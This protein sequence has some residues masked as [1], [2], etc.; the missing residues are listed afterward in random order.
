M[1][2]THSR[3]HALA[4]PV[5][6]DRDAAAHAVAWVLHQQSSLGGQV[7]LYVPQRDSAGNEPLLARLARSPGVVTATWRNYASSADWSGGPVLAA[8]PDADHL[9]RVDGDPRSRALC[10]L[11]WTVPDVDAWARARSPLQLGAAALEFPDAVSLDPV[12]RVALRRL[13]QMVNHANNLAG[14]LD[15]RDAIAVLTVLHRAGYRLPKDEVCAFALAQGW[16][17]RGARRLRDWAGEI[18]A[19]VRKRVNGPWPLREDV[20]EVWRGESRS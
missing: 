18:D 20:I 8:W 2:E 13:G 9:G 7:L 16:P 12:V 6:Q 1:S 3:P 19:G 14:V 11:A 5:A 4:G 15:R 10:V 17:D